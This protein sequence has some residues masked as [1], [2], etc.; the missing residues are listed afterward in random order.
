VSDSPVALV[1]LPADEPERALRFWSGLLGVDLEE[2]RDG[3]GQGWQTHSGGTA[4]GVH[5]RG[6]G[7]GDRGSLPYFAVADLAEAIGRVAELGG[8]VVHPGEQFAVCRD[9]EGNPFGLARAR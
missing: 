6:P 2:R 3:E 4:L 5:A 7:P 8:T 1:E 9:S